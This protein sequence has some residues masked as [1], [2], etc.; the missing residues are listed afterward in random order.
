M[1]SKP[2]RASYCLRTEEEEEI[3]AWGRGAD[4]S[5]FVLLLGPETFPLQTVTSIHRTGKNLVLYSTLRRPW[6]ILPQK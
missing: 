1:S 5:L 6:C 4:S 3:H 2:L